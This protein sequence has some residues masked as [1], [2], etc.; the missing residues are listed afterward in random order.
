MRFAEPLSLVGPYGT[1]L[2]LAGVGVRSLR[3]VVR[4][5][6]LPEPGNPRVPRDGTVELD[7]VT[8]GY[9]DTPV[10]RGFTLLCRP[11]TMTALVGPSGAGKTTVTR[12]VARFW[13]V[14]GGSVR[15]GGVDVRDMTTETL[16]GQIAMVFQHTYLFD[17]TIA[18][19]VRL[20]RPGAGDDEV[21]AAARAARLD[22]VVER[23]PDGWDTVVGEG[24]SRLSGGERQRVAIARA[25]LKDAPVVL[26]DEVTAALDTENEAAVAEA[27][28]GLAENRTVLVIAHRLATIAGA[29]RIAFVDGG[30]VVESGT[31]AELL[32]R[33]GPYAGFW[34][35]RAGAAA[36][37]SVTARSRPHR[38]T[39]PR[40]PR[41]TDRCGRPSPAPCPGP[42]RSSPRCSPSRSPVAARPR[43][44]PTRRGRD[45]APS[46]TRWVPPRCPRTPG[47]S[48]RST[49]TRR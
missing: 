11:Q 1:G 18:D 5:P 39:R 13:D 26:L 46:P 36:G 40:T 34:A 37:G 4:T 48:S 35:D 30:G 24:G 47:G 27:L 10:L 2:Q 3:E 19:N 16:M 29:D 38:P 45:R 28:T 9:G 31:H 20:G 22:E 23:L 42:P 12:L 14:D 32:E 41:R 7:G 49:S 25:L 43:P 17:A 8:F 33:A 15:I 21:R 6:P 44:P